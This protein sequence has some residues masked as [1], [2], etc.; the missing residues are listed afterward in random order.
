M[1]TMARGWTSGGTIRPSGDGT[2]Y[3]AARV[4]LRD[5]K[6]P[7]LATGLATSARPSLGQ[8]RSVG[9]VPREARG[10]VTQPG[11]GCDNV[12]F[13]LLRKAGWRV[14]EGLGK[15]G[16]GA[17]EPLRVWRK[18]DRRGIGAEC[19]SS[20][21]VVGEDAPDKPKNSK[22]KKRGDGPGGAGE[23]SDDEP[24]DGASMAKEQLAL[25]AHVKKKA[26]DVA[27]HTSLFRAFKEEEPGTDMNPL[28]RRRREQDEA[29]SR[30]IRRR[31]DGRRRGDGDEP[32]GM[33]ANNPL[34][35]MFG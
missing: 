7:G 33:S 28:L 35:G 16:E 30:A 17:V 22:R 11:L 26:R 19:E 24:R 12:G 10:A 23:D 27:I 14:G 3:E 29:Q 20:G 5:D 18:G 9:G 4:P 8:R 1:T 2:H 15:N 25:A 21:H 31:R 34:R 6:S 13:R 32:D